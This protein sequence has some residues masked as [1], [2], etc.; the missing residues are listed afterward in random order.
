M[1]IYIRKYMSNI[2]IN[3]YSKWYRTSKL[4]IFYL[5]KY[6]IWNGVMGAIPLKATLKYFEF[7]VV[8]PNAWDGF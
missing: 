8:F 6:C 1:Q 4:Y 3:T 2:T 5:Y 7:Q